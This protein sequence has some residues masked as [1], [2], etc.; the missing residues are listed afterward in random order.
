MSYITHLARNR[1][2][3]SRLLTSAAIA[4]S[5]AVPAAAAG[6]ADPGSGARYPSDAIPGAPIPPSSAPSASQPAG[7]DG[8]FNFGDAAVGAG[9]TL[10]LVVLTG[11]GLAVRRNARPTPRSIG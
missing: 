4:V 2:R 8:G 5:L 1:S 3:T 9:A 6:Y 11:T 7:N 10:G